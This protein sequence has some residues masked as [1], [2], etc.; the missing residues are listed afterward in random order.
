M[1]LRGIYLVSSSL[2]DFHWAPRID[3][4]RLLTYQDLDILPRGHGEVAV[5]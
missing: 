2:S 3:F 1:D 5:C 4:R